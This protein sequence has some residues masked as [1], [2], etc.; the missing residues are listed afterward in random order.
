MSVLFELVLALGLAYIIHSCAVFC[1]CVLCVCVVGMIFV[2]S[3][4]FS[5]SFSYRA[6]WGWGVSFSFINWVN[7]IVPMVLLLPS[8]PHL[9]DPVGVNVASVTDQINSIWRTGKLV[10]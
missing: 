3:F 8:L 10:S 5:F 1:V 2:F 9:Y 6:D 7:T 4:S